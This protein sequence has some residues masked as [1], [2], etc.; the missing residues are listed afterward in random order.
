MTYQGGTFGYQDTVENNTWGLNIDVSH[1][2][3]KAKNGSSSQAESYNGSVYILTKQDYFWYKGQAGVASSYYT[4]SMSIPAFALSAKNK[5]NQM[6]VY[7]DNTVYSPVDFYG[8]RPFAG[9]LVSSSTIRNTLTVG[10]QL[11]NTTPKAGTTT[12]GIPYAGLRYEFDKNVS[13]EYRAS[14]SPDF[15]TVHGVRAS[16][17]KEIDKDVYLDFVLGSEKGSRGYT[18]TYGMVGLVWKF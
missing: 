9:A 8:F 3:S 2:E 4:N 15:K 12:F 7:M 16:V 18:N 17:K 6:N 10:S 1:G 11:L 14:Q 13:I 5:A